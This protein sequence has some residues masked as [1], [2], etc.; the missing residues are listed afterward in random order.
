MGSADD[1]LGRG[2]WWCDRRLALLT[3]DVMDT[4]ALLRRMWEHVVWGDRQLWDAVE[5][6]AGSDLWKE[7]VHILGAEEVWLSR[8]ERRASRAAVW[9]DLAVAEAGAL[10]QANEDGYRR[11]LVDVDPG[12]LAIPLEYRNTAGQPFATTPADILTHVA[13]HGQYHRGKI[14]QMLR[15]NGATPTPV[16]FISWARGSPAARTR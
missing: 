11:W 14:N 2:I 8:L 3:E 4:F 15:Q 9:P 6:H 12:T 5:Q 1:T 16:D 7:Y 13:L 10:R